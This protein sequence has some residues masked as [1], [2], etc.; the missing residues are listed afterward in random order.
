MNKKI[1]SGLGIAATITIGGVFIFLDGSEELENGK[2]RKEV[3]DRQENKR[4]C[5]EIL[6]PETSE[7]KWECFNSKLEEIKIATARGI[8]KKFCGTESEKI[9]NCPEWPIEERASCCCQPPLVPVDD[10]FC[11]EKKKQ[12][13]KFSK[14]DRGLLCRGGKIAGTKK[15]CNLNEQSLNCIEWPVRVLFGEEPKKIIEQKTNQTE[16]M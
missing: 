5:A 13:T 16:G 2:F 12:E 1:L 7:T 8:V 14:K 4:Y 3:A 15:S 6:I 11:G 9:I 10:C